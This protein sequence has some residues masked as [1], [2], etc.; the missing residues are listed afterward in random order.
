L[1]LDLDGLGFD[2]GPELRRALRAVAPDGR[3]QLDPDT[4]EQ[5]LARL[6]LGLMEFLRQLMELQALR[7]YEAGTLTEAQEEAL[8]LTLM[9]AAGALRDLADR[10][11]LSEAD[12]HLDLGPLGTLT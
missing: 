3:L 7:R 12:L 4:V 11:G 10:F 9:R 1:A 2:P 5:D 6:V 8:G